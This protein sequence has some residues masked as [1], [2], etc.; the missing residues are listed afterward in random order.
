[1][2]ISV[3]V[4]QTL[5]TWGTIAATAVTLIS[6]VGL[7]WTNSRIAEIGAEQV[8]ALEIELSRT[9]P[10]VGSQELVSVNVLENDKY[11]H[12]FKILV[13]SPRSNMVFV[14]HL[15]SRANKVGGVQAE[16]TGSSGVDTKDGKN[17]GYQIYTYSFLTDIPLDMNTESVKI[18]ATPKEGE[19][20]IKSE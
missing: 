16:Y 11:R 9:Q 6:A 19:V 12:T 5:F 2:D 7:W 15:T 8:R 14:T 10:I 1:M 17:L 20:Y 13:Y 4:L 18:S 3:Q